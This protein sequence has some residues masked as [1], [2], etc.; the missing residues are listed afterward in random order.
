MSHMLHVFRKDV[1]R[2]RW[3]MAAWIAV[4]VGRQVLMMAGPALSFDSL[5]LQ[6]VI[7]NVS[8]LLM[9]A[10]PLSGAR[11]RSARVRSWPGR[12]RSPPSSSS[13]HRWSATRSRWLS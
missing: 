7:A 2:L 9:S 11:D 1:G 8:E 4:V 6:I 5:G 10:R 13:P 12:H 3:A